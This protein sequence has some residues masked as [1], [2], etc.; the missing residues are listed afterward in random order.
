VKKS[1]R[2]K[3]A[4]LEAKQKAQQEKEEKKRREAEENMTPK[5][6]FGEIVNHGFGVTTAMNMV[7][8]ED[9]PKSVNTN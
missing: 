7:C 9:V 4:K 8:V 5:H 3:L 6:L 2:K 1:N